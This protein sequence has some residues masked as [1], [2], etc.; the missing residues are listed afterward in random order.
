M[1]CGLHAHTR[2]RARRSGAEVCGTA[3]L[4]ML[5][6]HESPSLG[7]APELVSEVYKLVFHSNTATSKS[8][9]RTNYCDFLTTSTYIY[10]TASLSVGGWGGGAGSTRA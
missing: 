6:A 5:N 8:K 3:Y 4:P 1:L 7:T 2:A 9:K 10:V